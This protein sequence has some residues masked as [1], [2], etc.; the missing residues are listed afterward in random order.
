MVTCY[1]LLHFI[2]CANC[3]ILLLDQAMAHNDVAL[4]PVSFIRHFSFVPQ[5]SYP[6]HVLTAGCTEDQAQIKFRQTMLKVNTE[7]YLYIVMLSSSV[8]LYT[9]VVVCSML[10]QWVGMLSNCSTEHS[11]ILI[12]D[13]C[14]CGESH[15][16]LMSVLVPSRFFVECFFPPISKKNMQMDWLW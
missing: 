9:K 14:L 10:V 13:Y 11:S 12:S 16:F 5:A 6:L 3:R 1:I 8:Y 4:C 15:V 2:Y 7:C